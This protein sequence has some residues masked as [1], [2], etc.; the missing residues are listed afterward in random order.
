[1][2]IHPPG[3]RAIAAFVV[4]FALRL[5][6]PAS[7]QTTT[8]LV[9]T[10]TAWRSLKGTA[11]PSPSDRAAWRTAA[12]SDAAWTESK[13]PFWYGEAGL[14]GGTGTELADMQNSY[15]TLF[16]RRR[17]TLAQPAIFESIEL[18][19]RCDDGFIAWINGRLVASFN[20]PTADPA[21][22]ALAGA[23]APE[24]ANFIDYPLPSALSAL[25]PGENVLA[26]QVFNTS[27]GSSDIVFDAQLTATTRPSLQP[28]VTNVQPTPGPLSSLDR[29]TVT[30]S[31]PVRGVQADDFLINGA[32]AQRVEG[33]G[34]TYTFFFAQPPFGTVDIRWGT[35][36]AIED[37]ETPPRR[38]EISAEGSI[39]GYELIDPLGP[40]IANR[41]PPAGTTVSSLTE[42]QVTFDKAVTGVDASDLLRNGL[43]ATQVTGLGAGP[44]R[45]EFPAS[46]PG[47]ANLS[48]SADHGIVSD[49]LEPHP[50]AGSAWSYTINPQFIPAP[51]RITE[52]MAENFTTLRDEDQDPEDWI[53]IHNPTA[54]AVNLE[55]WSLSNDAEDPELWV[56]PAVSIAPN[57]SLVVVAS[58]KDR[59]PTNPALRLH[60]S[61]KLNPNGGY[62]GLFPP[63]LPR[64]AVSEVTYPEQG[65]NHAY[66]RESNTGAWRYFLNGTPGSVNGTSPIRSAVAEVHFSV[67]RGFFSGTFNLSLS[68][69]TPGAIIRFT[70]NGS[71][72]T[73]TD[74]FLYTN[75]I[76]I[77]VSRV[78]RAAA[79]LSNA[80]PSRI[81]THTYLVNQTATRQRIPA[82][83]LV[84]ATNNLFGRTGIM[85]VNPRNTTKRGAAWERPVS[86]EWIRPDG[87]T[88]FQ[89]DCGLRLQGGDYVRGQY[90]YRT[91]EIPFSKYSFRLYFR[92]EY[93]Q[94]RLHYPLFPETTQTSFDTVVLRAGMNDAL[95]PYLTDEFVRSLVRDTGQPSPA[96]TFVHLFLNGVY[97]GYYNPCERIDIDFLRAYH[98]GGEKWDVM[99]QVG[100]VRE[101]DATAF[102][103]L[104][105]IAST[106]DLTVATNFR[107]VASR[108]DLTNFVDYLLP[109]IY[110]DNDDWPHNN[111]RA[112]RERVSGGPYRMYCWDAEWAFGLVNGHAPTWDTI[113]NQLS[114]TSPPW[115]SADIQRIFIGLKKSPEFRQFFADRVH[116]H[117]FNGGVLT[118]ERLRVRYAGLTN[119]LAGI[120]SGFNNRIA[121][122]WIPQRRKNVL[123]HLERAGLIASSNAPAF[124]QFGGRVPDGFQLV[125]TNL[126]GTVYYTTNGTD[127]RV[128]L[129]GEVSPDAR[130]YTSPLPMLHSAML[131]A[132]TLTGTNWSAVT[133]APFEVDRIGIPLVVSE[134]MY[135]PPGGEPFEFLE[136]HNHGT[137]PLNLA[138][139]SFSG[140]EFRFPNPFPLMPGGA[141]WI[142][143]NRSRPSDFAAR[144]P[145]VTVAGWFDGSLNNGGERIEL[146]A[147]DGSLVTAVD[148]DDDAPWPT[149]ADGLGAS[150]EFDDTTADPHDPAAWLAS[151][152]TG[153]SPA[154]PSSPQPVPSLRL[155]EITA[156]LAPAPDWIEL[157]NFGAAVVQLAGWSLSDD[158]D[159]TRFVFPQD[160]SIGPGA[161]LRIACGTN[162]TES[163][164]GLRT[165]F[166]LS[167]QGETIALYNPQHTR[168]DAVTFGH[169]P[170]GF[171]LGRIGTSLDWQLT[172]PSPL[173]PNEPAP[174]ESPAS[175]AINEWM[176]NPVAGDDDWIEFHNRSTRAPIALKGLFVSTSNAV[177]QIRTHAFVGP[178]GFAVLK[179]DQKPGA[180][181]LA[182]K[183]PSN[184][185]TIL[186]SDSDGTEINRVTY[187]TPMAGYP[188]GAEGISIGRLP[189]GTGNLTA[190]PGTVSPAAP[191]YTAPPTGPR[192]NEFMAAN[193]GSV[194]HPSGR[195]AD[196][197]E[198]RNPS[199]TS[200]NLAGA[201]LAVGDDASDGW[202]FPTGVSIPPQG[203]LVVWM[204]AALPTS[205]VGTPP[206]QIGRGLPTE[207]STLRLI[208]PQGQV[209]DSLSYGAQLPDRSAGLSANAWTLLASPT[210]GAPNSGNAPLGNTGSTR[211][212]EWLAGPVSGSDWVELHNPDPLPIDLGGHFLTEDPSLAGTR[213]FQIAPLTFIPG[214]GH[215]T[216]MADERADQGPDHLPFQL[217][218][219]GETLRLYTPSRTP[220]DSLSFDPQFPGVAS[221]RFPDGS[222]GIVPFPGSESPKESNWLQHPGLVISEV[223]THTDPPLEDAIELHNPTARPIALDGWRVS[224]AV[225]DLDKYRFPPRT[226]IGPG[227]RLV[228]FEKDFNAPG[229]PT[230]FTL[231]SAHGDEVW[232][233]EVNAT[234][235]LTGYRAHAAFGAAANGISFGLHRTSIGWD[236]PPLSRLTFG[237][238]LPT[239]TAEF[240]LG[241]GLPNAY[242]LVGPVVVTEIHFNPI[243]LVDTQ[244]TD[245]PDDEYIEIHNTDSR[246]VAL[247]DPN[248]PTNT[249]RLRGGI[250]F[251]FPPGITLQPS[252][253]ALVVRFSPSAPE[254]A[255]FRSRR[256][257]PAGIRLFG[258]FNGRLSNDGDEIRLER[259]DRPQTAPAPDA[260]F[261]PYL[262]VERVAYLASFPWPVA[263][264]DQE[265]SLQRKQVLAY[266]NDPVH[267]I[268]GP[269]SP[270]IAN[271]PPL[272]DRDFDG[273]PNDWEITFGLNADLATDADLDPDQDG[274]SNLA[275]YLAGT[276][277]KDPSSALT[278]QLS[279]EPSAGVVVRFLAA[280]HRSYSILQRDDPSLGV[281]RKIADVPADSFDRA[282][283]V[284]LGLPV[285][286]AGFLQ[287][288][289]PSTP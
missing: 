215:L 178:S 41:Q 232:I 151:V 281:W 212:N 261:V 105:T 218:E 46:A 174:L 15:S 152:A 203:Y 116:R 219:R 64:H 259:P 126:A 186:L 266:A 149:Q 276:H 9:D 110:V 135:N 166:S 99:A 214:R 242:P 86:V 192:F 289:T 244:W 155:S 47:A 23:N 159:P 39:W 72:P 50:F 119:R 130:I 140:I 60:T 55:G 161:W 207:G 107:D 255:S 154:V 104:R 175:L 211:I 144:Y 37:F 153:G 68:C 164:S 67:P 88:G 78:I 248:A 158:S 279:I 125:I 134:I 40:S 176:A 137:L 142:L 180:D 263:P 45:F 91:T 243:Q 112:A 206:L 139:F 204:D 58:A 209:L 108:L 90:N 185:G 98:G 262:L 268:V 167:R 285:D 35:L 69:P 240:R 227:G 138:G 92:G 13:T 124:S 286:A 6:H 63:D 133:E 252:E 287:V 59:R 228:L 284:P 17:F 145:N 43:A 288:V 3:W 195:F 274:L 162:A 235:D 220:I 168:I 197:I 254:A 95:N 239:S 19:A 270:G 44:Y 2:R 129:T 11:E 54:S 208:D 87:D 160:A 222:D 173:A 62:L 16:L 182:L 251:D 136:L 22:N 202:T 271:P 120:V 131:R 224:N 188:V 234:G 245:L 260:G 157:R 103:T 101:G 74:G 79:F 191:N 53:E 241:T 198:L 73:L 229:T 256:Q 199:A 171:S 225:R 283:V 31:E 165:P 194:R 82:I 249:W 150:L 21:F 30:F 184:A 196:W 106:R 84:T 34:T 117:F 113:R 77:N 81:G 169:L 147:A 94:G 36:H 272:T 148:Y 210:P 123:Q 277:P 190:F 282:A 128:A 269:P 85:E 183:I 193:A 205:T 156:A 247:F 187:Q 121:T 217:D 7:G 75:A 12:F 1:M 258:P 56:F 275:E 49:A 264:A 230:A 32:S 80:L 177:A 253:H 83:S 109:L 246:P 28:V 93:G 51:L 127:P 278:L 181:H 226:V 18:S 102:N 280:A 273:M 132:R 42:V 141:R 38:F 213:K 237:K 100:E 163:I 200:Y 189:D 4:L 216:W 70:T 14:F 25:V 27:L 26:V 146:L 236:F 250:A 33:S 172:E 111:W 118:D 223:L 24:P 48:F 52:F 170:D 221:G 257:L 76:P 29:I 66:G 10:N 89:T 267:W 238:D 97:K 8:V 61:F 179:A 71:P 231:N 96:G 201:S 57:A 143:A 20:P 122:T 65:P 233:S 114:S 115:G 5:A 265:T